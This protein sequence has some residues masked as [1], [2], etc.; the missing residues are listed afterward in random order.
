MF[1]EI[2]RRTETIRPDPDLL[3]T[4]RTGPDIRGRLLRG[5]L[6]LHDKLLSLNMGVEFVRRRGGSI[7]YCSCLRSDRGFLRQFFVQSGTAR[8][9]W[10][11]CQSL[12]EKESACGSETHIRCNS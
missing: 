11:F 9:G 8:G 10:A 1:A 2:F 7:K 12:H 5:L 4:E 3:L 6:G